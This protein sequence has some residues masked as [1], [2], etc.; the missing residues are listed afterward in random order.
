MSLRKTD[1]WSCLP[2]IHSCT[3]TRLYLV[4][5][6]VHKYLQSVLYLETSI[7]I[8]FV[9]PLFHIYLFCQAHDCLVCTVHLIDERCNTKKQ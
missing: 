5:E 9:I 6:S 1:R 8:D 4:N 7:S 2:S 3:V